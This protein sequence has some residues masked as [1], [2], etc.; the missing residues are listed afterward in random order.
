MNSSPLGCCNGQAPTGSHFLNLQNEFCNTL[1]STAHEGHHLVYEGITVNS[2]NGLQMSMYKSHQLLTVYHWWVKYQW[3]CHKQLVSNNTMAIK[4]QKQMKLRIVLHFKRHFKKQIK[5]NRLAPLE[6]LDNI[7][8][9]KKAKKANK[10]RPA[11]IIYLSTKKNWPYTHTHTAENL[12]LHT[13]TH[14]RKCYIPFTQTQAH[15]QEKNNSSKHKQLKECYHSVCCW[16]S[17]STGEVSLNTCSAWLRRPH[18]TIALNWN[19]THI[20]KVKFIILLVGRKKK[21]I[22]M[23]SAES[24]TLGSA[25]RTALLHW[26]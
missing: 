3:D 7:R 11:S 17:M 4:T 19:H 9:F 18:S 21:K 2:V 25:D 6:Y 22:I 14:C 24:N 10:K 8:N 15:I 20:Q 26:T 12:T 1:I 5:N 16:L 13:Y 23:K